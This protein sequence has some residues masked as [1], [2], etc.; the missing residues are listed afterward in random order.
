MSMCFARGH[1]VPG[2]ENTVTDVDGGEMVEGDMIM[3]RQQKAALYNPSNQSTFG[4]SIVGRRW[5]PKDRIPYQIEASVSKYRKN[6]EKAIEEYH[7][8]T[9]IRF[10]KETS[11][12]DG[13]KLRNYI[14]FYSGSGCNSPVGMWNRPNRISLGRGCGGVGTIIHEIAH[15][16]GVWH[17][18]MRPDRDRYV[19]IIWQN[20][21]LS[22]KGN[23]EMA[24]GAET[25]NTPY[26]FDS[27]M[28]YGAT[29]F[30]SGKVTI[31][32]KDSR[33]RIGQRKGLSTGDVKL[34]KKMYKCAVG[35]GGGTGT[36]KE[37]ENKKVKKGGSSCEDKK[38]TCATWKDADYCT[39]TYVDYMKTNCPKACGHCT[40][41]STEAPRPS[42]TPVKGG[43]SSCKDKKDTCGSWK[44]SGYCTKTY[45]D[46][47]KKNCP[48]AC[49]H[50]TDE[51][52][53]PPPKPEPPKPGRVL[54]GNYG[55]IWRDNQCPNV[56]NA[57][58]RISVKAC[59]AACAAHKQCT[60][61]NYARDRSSCVLR[62]C[63][64]PVASPRGSLTGYIGLKM[65]EDGGTGKSG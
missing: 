32:V 3:T 26:D 25:L 34:L 35:G 44:N 61:V 12:E 47:M 39:K 36:K 1:W 5:N 31:R 41:R 9:C 52:K 50:C 6:I 29:A 53:K 60:A 18:Q 45:V 23:F 55:K 51:E 56:G 40:A 16:L 27:I 33:Y 49:G 14:S 4:L 20:I 58:N 30:G 24:K 46:Y 10:V 8:K 15:S 42:P 54:W 13:E 38:D 2:M 21:P 11:G 28:H 43:G 37:K 64:W 7:Q 22:V 48:K 63:K 57:G 19:D 59:K 62:A 65:I 17:E